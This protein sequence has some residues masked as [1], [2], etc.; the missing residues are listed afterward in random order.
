MSFMKKLCDVYDAVIGTDGAKGGGAL[1]PVGFVQ[2]NIKYNIILSPAGEFVTAQ[3]LPDDEQACAVPSSPQAEARTSS[4][5]APFPLAEQLKYLIAGNDSKYFD[6]YVAQLEAWCAAEHAPD[7]LRVLLNYLK[8]KTLYAD[9]A[10]VSGLK[11]KY[12]KDEN[13]AKGDGADAKSFACFS[14]EYPDSENRL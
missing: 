4:K 9:L 8:K 12:Y 2:K 14:V 13:D 1:L 5:C 3:I 11:L 10:A 7:C 6:S